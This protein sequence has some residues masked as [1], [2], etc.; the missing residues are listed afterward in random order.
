MSE[1]AFD[2]RGLGPNFADRVLE[3]AD[4]ELARRR[5]VRRLAVTAVFLG[6]AAAAAIWLDLSTATQTPL[7]EREAV[8]AAER[9]L[10]GMDQTSDTSA[11]PL[12]YMFPDAEPLARYAAEDNSTDGDAGALF[13]DQETPDGG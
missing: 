3:A 5:H 4:R 12:S 8:F 10:Q 13:D 6:G 1:N 7:G 2:E 9:G 11:D